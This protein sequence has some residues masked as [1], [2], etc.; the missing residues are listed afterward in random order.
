MVK[1]NNEKLQ[2]YINIIFERHKN[3]DK[4]NYFDKVNLLKNKYNNINLLK[5]EHMHNESVYGSFKFK[6]YDN[7]I[8]LDLLLLKEIQFEKEIK[9]NKKKLPKKPA[10]ALGA[11]KVQYPK[12]KGFYMDPQEVNKIKQMIKRLKDGLLIWIDANYNN[13]ENKFYLK[14]LSENKY[15]IVKC[16]HNVDDAFIY[17]QKK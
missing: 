6:N 17:F 11:K 4:Y 16:F 12:E 10:S 15:L 13:Q 1:L 3:Y 2:A 9:G 5:T 8:A 7:S 14:L